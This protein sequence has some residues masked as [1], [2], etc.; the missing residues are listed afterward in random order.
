M[1]WK[2]EPHALGLGILP[3]WL[4]SEREYLGHQIKRGNYYTRFLACDPRGWNGTTFGE[5]KSNTLV[6]KI[7]NWY[8]DGE[9]YTDGV[10][11]P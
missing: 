2:F 3:P 4:V 1:Y 5:T 11:T 10:I 8:V 7:V 6:P 9:I